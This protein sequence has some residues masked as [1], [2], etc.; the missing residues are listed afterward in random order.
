MKTW[1]Q[2]L[3]ENNKRRSFSSTQINIEGDLKKSI[4]DTGNKIDPD[5]VDQ[6]EG[7]EAEPHVTVLYGLHTSNPNDVKKIV[8]DYQY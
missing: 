7:L 5:D 4:I 2:F 3:T 8:N 1:L 6:T